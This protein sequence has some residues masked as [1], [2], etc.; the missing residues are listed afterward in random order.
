MNPLFQAAVVALVRSAMKVA[1]GY[2]VAKGIWTEA[3]A[4][5]Y[6]MAAAL[7]VVSE[8]WSQLVTF[9]NTRWKATAVALLNNMTGSTVPNMTVKDIDKAI[10][11]GISAP[12]S[13][14]TDAVPTL[15]KISEDSPKE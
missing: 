13:T 3:D 7:F 8:G 4:E 1:A 10:A 6:V 5:Q 9:W 15:T 12:A 11:K 2:I 14:P